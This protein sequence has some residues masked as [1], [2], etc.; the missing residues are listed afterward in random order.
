MSLLKRKASI[1]LVV[2]THH[3]E[4]GSGGRQCSG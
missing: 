4:D 3:V 1:M 2:S